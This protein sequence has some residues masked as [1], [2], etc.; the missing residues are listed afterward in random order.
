VSDIATQGPGMTRL[1][2]KALVTA[3]SSNKD[4][5]VRDL[6][7]VIPL[8]EVV[9]R[10]Y[11]GVGFYTKFAS[12]ESIKRSDL[13]EAYLKTHP[14]EA[15][16]VYPGVSGCVNFLVWIGNGQVDCLEA[17]SSGSWPEDENQFVVCPFP[18]GAA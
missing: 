2:V 17:A 9:S 11:T 12:K 14:P 10:K 13:D 5:R 18:E 8:L 4:P 7:Y 1:E 3:L 6:F 16:G 15:L